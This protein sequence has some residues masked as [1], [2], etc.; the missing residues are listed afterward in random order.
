MSKG[1]VLPNEFRD[2]SLLRKE[3]DRVA[4]EA[5]YGGDYRLDTVLSEEGA[6]GSPLRGR[7]VA[8]RANVFE[9]PSAATAVPVRQLNLRNI[10][11]RRTNELSQ[12]FQGD[13]NV[14]TGLQLKPG[15]SE[16][17]KE[18]EPVSVPAEPEPAKGIKAKR[19]AKR[20]KDPPSVFKGRHQ[21]EAFLDVEFVDLVDQT[22]KRLAEYTLA[23]VEET[24]MQI[25]ANQ[26]LTEKNIKRSQLEFEKTTFQ[27]PGR[28]IPTRKTSDHKSIL[29]AAKSVLDDIDFDLSVKKDA[30]L[31]S[32]AS[33]GTE[34]TSMS[35]EDLRI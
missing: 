18:E 14:P 24:D 12:K 19:P 16:E 2:N 28:E 10:T 26:H 6:T 33:R 27:S 4:L 5:I 25:F 31:H 32:V 23:G 15:K 30:S 3:F 11:R 34:V 29:L 21:R 20:Y 13:P 7:R 35:H 22:N 17:T 9:N 8:E 1:E